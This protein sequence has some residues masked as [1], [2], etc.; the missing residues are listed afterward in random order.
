VLLISVYGYKVYG[1]YLIVISKEPSSE[2]NMKSGSMFAGAGIFSIIGVAGG[3]LA[4][5]ML[6]AV[7]GALLMAILGGALGSMATKMCSASIRQILGFNVSV[8]QP[9]QE[10]PHSSTTADKEGEETG[11][12]CR[13]AQE[14]PQECTLGRVQE[15]PKECTSACSA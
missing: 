11:G 9:A 14:T 8:K 4:F 6:G 5:G 2:A 3:G 13:G 7:L 1:E 15:T 12:G 10:Q